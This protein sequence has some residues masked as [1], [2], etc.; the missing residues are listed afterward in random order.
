MGHFRSNR[1]QFRP[2]LFVWVT[3]MTKPR[4]C[5][6][7]GLPLPE[8]SD[9]S[10]RYHPGEC[11]QQAIRENARRFYHASKYPKRLHS[12]HNIRDDFVEYYQRRHHE[13]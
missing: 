10:R 2:G 12:L 5:D 6:W 4:N 3:S 7:C 13:R 8:D 9:R 11:K 1:N